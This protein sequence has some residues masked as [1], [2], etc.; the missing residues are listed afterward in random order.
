MIL[1]F[2][3]HKPDFTQGCGRYCLALQHQINRINAMMEQTNHST[4]TLLASFQAGNMAAFSQLY[5]LHINVLFN[6]GLKLTIDKELL[7]DCIHD[8]FVKLY[9]KKDELGTIDNLRSYLF[10][11]LKN[12]L[13]DELRRRMY[14]SDTAV[15]EVSIST[16]TDVEDDYM[17][18]EQRKNEFSLVRRLL[19]QLSTRQREAL[20]LYYIEE[21]KYEDICEI[22]NMNYQSVRNLMYRGLTKLRDLAS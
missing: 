13:C 4:D 6:Y 15:E 2:S 1:V 9:T 11:S 3:I 12:K 14:M 7:K 18:E 16:P 22:M 5:N 8:I 19:D 17:E 10:I 20:T 21:K